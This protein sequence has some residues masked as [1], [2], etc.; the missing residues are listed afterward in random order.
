METKSRYEV[1]SDLEAKKRE[2]IKER[3]SLNDELR[4]KQHE[5]K[6]LERNGEGLIVVFDRNLKD[7]GRTVEILHREKADYLNLNDRKMRDVEIKREDLQRQKDDNI[8]LNQRKIEDIKVD[9]ENFIK[10]MN[11]RKETIK[12]LIT[13]V[14]E[15]IKR[16]N[17]QLTK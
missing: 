14:E 10:T 6:E 3:D 1:L 4:A 12:E 9:I 7:L 2:L 8:V 13:S 16:F 17:I 5:E 11:E 15:S